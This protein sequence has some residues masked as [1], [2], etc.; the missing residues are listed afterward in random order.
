VRIKK[1]KRKGEMRR[2]GE[3]GKKGEGRGGCVPMTVFK[4]SHAYVLDQVAGVRYG[5]LQPLPDIFKN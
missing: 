1:E 2:G 3:E 5:E 4:S